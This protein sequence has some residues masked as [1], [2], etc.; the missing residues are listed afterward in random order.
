MPELR[1][2]NVPKG[3]DPHREASEGKVRPNIA[4]VGVDL[5]RVWDLTLAF[6]DGDPDPRMFLRAGGASRPPDVQGSAE[7]A[8]GGGEE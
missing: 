7:A 8:Q 4:C 6:P 1:L 5:E 3:Q 2:H